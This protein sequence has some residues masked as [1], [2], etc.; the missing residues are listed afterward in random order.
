MIECCE[1]NILYITV[2]PSESLKKTL[3]LQQQNKSSKFAAAK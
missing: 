2:T 1:S 3:S